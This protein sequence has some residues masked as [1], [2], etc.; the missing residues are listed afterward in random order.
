MDTE[1]ERRARL[2]KDAAWNSSGRPLNRTKKEKQYWRIMVGTTT[3]LTLVLETDEE[4]RSNKGKDL[5]W[6]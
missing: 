2:E 4:R 3:L 6:I 5:V 1:E